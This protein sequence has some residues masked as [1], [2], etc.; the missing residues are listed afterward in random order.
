MRRQSL[1]AEACFDGSK[2]A[3]EIRLLPV[4]EDK[5][6][7][8]IDQDG[9]SKTASGL[10]PA[11]YPEQNEVEQEAPQKDPTGAEIRDRARQLWENR[12][13]PQGEDEVLWL[14]AERELRE[15][16]RADLQEKRKEGSVQ[17]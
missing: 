4:G 7:R 13:R 14:E 17:R 16:S 8:P 15:A 12:G 6:K 9:K 3:V 5:M 11:S 2:H 1:A 10:D